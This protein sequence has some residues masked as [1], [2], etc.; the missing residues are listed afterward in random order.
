ME[1]DQRSRWDRFRKNWIVNG[2]AAVILIWWLATVISES[3]WNSR[4]KFAPINACINNLR[5]IDGAKGAWALEKKPPTNATP[6]WDDLKPYFGSG[7]NAGILPK[8]PSGGVY[9]IGN[10]QTAPTCTVK[11]H[12][13]D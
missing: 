12:S 10:L 8:C 7:T 5:E 11:D 9:T 3:P 4:T 1:N 6:T 2:L 13:L